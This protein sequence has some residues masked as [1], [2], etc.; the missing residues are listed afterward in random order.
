VGRLDWRSKLTRIE[1]EHDN[2]R[3]ALGWAV[4]NQEVETGAR[5]AITLWWF[6]LERGYLSEDASG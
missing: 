5:L 3:A 1:R 4:Q 2:L 6:W